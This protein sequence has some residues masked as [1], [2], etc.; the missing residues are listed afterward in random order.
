MNSRLFPRAFLAVVV[1]AALAAGCAT[2]PKGGRAVVTYGDPAQYSD[3][4][5]AGQSRQQ[6]APKILADLRSSIEASARR[7][8]PAGYTVNVDVT[9]VDQAGFI[10]NPGGAFPIRTISDNTPAVIG[11][12]YTVTNAA[13]QSVKSGSQ[14]LVKTIN[15]IEPFLNQ[16]SPVSVLSYMMDDWLGSLGWELSRS[17]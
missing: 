7:S 5:I 15:D 2:S 16:D 12:N 6:S 4:Q 14:R 10:S 9:E 11:F 8:I 13:G 17:S 1:A 3:L